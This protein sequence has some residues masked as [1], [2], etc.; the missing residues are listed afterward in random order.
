MQPAKC[1]D[2]EAEFSCTMGKMLRWQSGF[3]IRV[4]LRRM[5]GGLIPTKEQYT[6][7]LSFRV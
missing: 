4:T 1:F 7:F 3:F 5:V 2:G 6:G